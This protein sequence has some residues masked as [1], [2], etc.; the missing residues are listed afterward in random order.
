MLTV[1][2]KRLNKDEVLTQIIV[3][4]CPFYDMPSIIIY[5]AD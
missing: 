4:V 3:L 1:F 2:S 5:Y